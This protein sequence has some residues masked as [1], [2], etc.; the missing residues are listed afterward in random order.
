VAEVVFFTGVGEV[1]DFACRLLRKKQREGE[2]V[3]VY[4]PMPLLQRLDQALWVAEPLDFTP[5]VLLRHGA[6]P[7]PAAVRERTLLWLLAEPQPALACGTAINLGRDDLDLA[8][9]HQRV[10]EVVS[11]DPEDR[12]SGRSRWKRYESAGDR[13]QHHPQR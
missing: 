8:R 7:P 4:G 6:A 10:A 1:L 9:I 3:A 12:A 11:N 13:L 5:H 2:R